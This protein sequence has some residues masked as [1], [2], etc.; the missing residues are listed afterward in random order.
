MLGHWG[1][2]VHLLSKSV[3]PCLFATSYCLC[4]VLDTPCSRPSSP[5]PSLRTPTYVPTPK[6][7]AHLYL[8]P[9]WDP[10]PPP[11]PQ[12]H[13]PV[14]GSGASPWSSSRALKRELFLREG[15][16]RG[17][18][19]SLGVQAVGL[20]QKEQCPEASWERLRNTQR[21]HPG[22]NSNL[23]PPRR[24]EEQPG[25]G[26]AR[27]QQVRA[28]WPG[29]WWTSIGGPGFCSRSWRGWPGASASG[30][31]SL[32]GPTCGSLTALWPGGAGPREHSLRA[33]TWLLGRGGS[34]CAR[35]PAAPEDCALLPYAEESGRG[36]SC[37]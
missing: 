37:S 4:F 32:Q 15:L 20:A 25:G 16:G 21:W 3:L 13:S 27:Q 24:R 19:P 26:C 14:P 5:W 30:K 23:D 10:P 1:R 22:T 2:S 12:L 11:C 31:L 33:V 28:L 18:H 36:P 7:T 6:A 17:V 29:A 34:H 8:L 35:R 9:S